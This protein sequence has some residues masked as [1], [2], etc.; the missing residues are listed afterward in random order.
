M[1]RTAEGAVPPHPRAGRVSV[2]T[3]RTC[4]DIDT[5]TVTDI[6]TDTVTDIDT[7]TETDI[8]TD[9]DTDIDTDTGT[10]TNPGRHRHIR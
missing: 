10:G 9:T 2:C 7:D 4:T 3:A 6:D 5:D 1:Q 8:D